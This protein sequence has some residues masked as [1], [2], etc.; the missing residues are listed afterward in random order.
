MAQHGIFG[1]GP[2][3]AVRLRR[4][5]ITNLGFIDQ[6]VRAAPAGEGEE[7]VVV[8]IQ[9]LGNRRV[10]RISLAVLGNK[11]LATD[12]FVGKER[13]LDVHR[14]LWNLVQRWGSWGLDR[15]ILDGTCLAFNR[16]VNGPVIS[17]L[18]GAAD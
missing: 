7:D 18:P 3:L 6:T 16:P 14:N 12:A 2:R 5:E 17:R 15:A 13:D 1:E 10:T 8:L 9:E 11:N 4:R